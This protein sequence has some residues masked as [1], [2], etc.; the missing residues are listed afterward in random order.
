MFL[1]SAP[2]PRVLLGV[3]LLPFLAVAGACGDDGTGPSGSGSM[4]AVLVDFPIGGGSALAGAFEADVEVQVS[5]DGSAWE[6]VGAASSV[7]VGLQADEPVTVGGEVEVSG[8][9]Y[10]HVRATVSGAVATLDAG[11]VVGGETLDEPARIEVAGGEEVVV[12]REVFS[13]RVDAET[14]MTVVV[15]VRSVDWVTADVA[16]DGSVSSEA[17]RSAVVVEARRS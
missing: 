15:D 10:R 6:N 5:A 13:F 9:D 3:A 2:L 12:E 8:G 1:S 14:A 16:A 7:V 11:S 4:S 17:F